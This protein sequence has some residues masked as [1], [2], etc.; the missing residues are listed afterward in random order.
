[1]ELQ[2]IT[3]NT[4][5]ADGMGVTP[6]EARVDRRTTITYCVAERVTPCVWARKTMTIG[7]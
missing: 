2:I 5:E 1:M 4:R 7:K 3:I 6:I